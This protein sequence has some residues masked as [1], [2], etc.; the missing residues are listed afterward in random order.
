MKKTLLLLS[1]LIFT[2]YS[3]FGQDTIYFDKSGKETTLKE[4][5]D[6][7]E[8]LF[9]DAEN[10]DKVVVRKFADNGQ[11]IYEFPYS[12]YEEKIAH[13]TYRTWYDAGQ[14]RSEKKY[15]NGES[16][17]SFITYWENGQKKREDQYENNKLKEGTTWDQLGNEV[18]YY[19]F[20]I[21]PEFPG[22][23]KALVKYLQKNAKKPKN[24][25]GGRVV[26]GFIVDVDGAITDISI[27]ETTSM[28]LNF[29]AYE[30]VAQ[31]P[32][33]SPGRQDG[34]P[35]KVSYALPLNFR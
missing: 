28:G 16:H 31:M 34:K 32:R 17:G 18:P 2:S 13:G 30:V 5:A 22:G 33:W 7:Y 21:R 29:P 10:P 12:S 14:L 4:A 15:L 20:E 6:D 3:T 19:E 27:K 11:L 26:V 35:V 25:A 8:V 23:Q 24:A 9:K 1:F